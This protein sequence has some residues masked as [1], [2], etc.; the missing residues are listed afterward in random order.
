MNGILGK[1]VVKSIALLVGMCATVSPAWAHVT[2][3]A[4][5]GGEVLGV[6]CTVEIRWRIDIQHNQLNWDL[7][8]STT[9]SG[10]PWIAIAMDLPPGSFAVGSI[11]TYDWTVP[12]DASNQVRVRVR[13]DN[14][15]TDYYDISNGDLS[16]VPPT[17]PDSF[18]LF[19]GILTGGGLNELLASDDSWMTVRPGITLGQTEP[20]V[21]LIVIGTAPTENPTELRFRVEAHADIN[22][23]GQWI[24]LFNYITNSYDLVD[25][26]IA[27]TV[28]SI[29]EVTITNDPW[30]YVQAGTKEMTAKV[31][32]LEAGI[33]LSYPWL[34]SIDQTVWI[35]CD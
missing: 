9:G 23:I 22:N 1:S 21:Q 32:Y 28:D 27:T 14:S 7:W 4:P 11:H 31:S 17:R 24:E 34:V 15:G 20:S 29:V 33:I 30:R 10:G 6:G 35:I 2:L 16:I 19:R 18:W 8:Y 13:M 5:N 3:Q 25:F 12:D 26:M